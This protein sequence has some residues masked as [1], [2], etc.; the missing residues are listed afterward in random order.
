[1]NDTQ[2]DRNPPHSPHVPGEGEGN[3]KAPPAALSTRGRAHVSLHVMKQLAC[4]PFCAD[5][6]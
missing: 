5:V 3:K 1:M 4:Y 2:S 6:I